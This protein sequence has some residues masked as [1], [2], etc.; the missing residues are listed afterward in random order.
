MSKSTK[1]LSEVYS[2][3]VGKRQSQLLSTPNH[4]TLFNE[5][6][7]G[8]K[9]LTLVEAIWETI[10]EVVVVIAEIF[11]LDQEQLLSQILMDNRRLKAM[12]ELAKTA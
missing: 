12:R 1:V 5:I 4:W 9:E 3:F 11:C 2:F 10:V 6:H 8:V 7:L